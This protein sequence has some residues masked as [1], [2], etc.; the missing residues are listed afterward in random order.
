MKH[1]RQSSFGGGCLNMPHGAE[2][3][4]PPRG[5]PISYR[6]IPKLGKSIEGRN[7]TILDNMYHC[8]KVILSGQIIN[9]FT[10]SLGMISRFHIIYNNY[11]F[12]IYAFNIIIRYIIYRTTAIR[13]WS[14]K[15]FSI[16]TTV[17]CLDDLKNWCV[18]LDITITFYPYIIGNY[19]QWL[20]IPLILRYYKSRQ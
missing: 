4:R 19:Y 13:R 12:N 6:L 10:A 16:D 15:V 20:I 7:E 9:T 1:T 8:W 3:I 5:N 18:L 14:C 11:A 2:I 17:G